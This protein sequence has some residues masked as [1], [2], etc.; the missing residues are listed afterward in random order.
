[1]KKKDIRTLL[2]QVASAEQNFMETEFLAPV[3]KGGQVRVRIEGLVL[4]LRVTGSFEPG[5]AIL[6]A[7]SMDRAQILRKPGLQQIRSYLALFPAIRLLL[8][9]RADSDWLAVQAQ[10]GDSR[11]QIGGP[12]PVHLA[13]GV[14]PFE[15]IVARFDGTRFLFQEVDRRRTP[16]IAAYLREALAS[17]TPPEQLRKPTL[18]A[19]ERE[20]YR[21]IYQ[22]L[23]SPQLAARKEPVD[24]ALL[25]GLQ[26]ILEELVGEIAADG[27]VRS[28]VALLT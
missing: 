11:F 2:S 6:K 9:A 19:E 10:A 4:T 5:W 14:E 12:V 21:K 26:V 16:A 20:A 3:L 27:L 13:I 18:T 1:M 25:V 22:A 7:V 24:R 8:L 15:R 23:E 28:F 17:G